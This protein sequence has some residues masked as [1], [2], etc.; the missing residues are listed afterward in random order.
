MK[1][2]STLLH[3][4]FGL[5]LSVEANLV[6]GSE[7]GSMLLKLPTTWYWNQIGSFIANFSINLVPSQ[8]KSE[9][10][11]SSSKETTPRTPKSPP[12]PPIPECSRTPEEGQLFH[13][14]TFPNNIQNQDDYENRKKI[15]CNYTMQAEENS[16]VLLTF[17]HI[18]ISSGYRCSTAWLKVFYPNETV[19]ETFCG[20]SSR[21]FQVLSESNELRLN[22]FADKYAYGN[23]WL[24][25]WQSVPAD[26]EI[27]QDTDDLYFL[28]HPTK[29]RRGVEEEVCVDL[30][31][32]Y[33]D[34]A[35]VSVNF[36][37]HD[38]ES[39][40]IFS[41]EPSLSSV[42][43]QGCSS[44]VL[45][46]TMVESALMRLTIKKSEDDMEPEEVYRF[47]DL[48][49]GEKEETLFQ[50]DKGQYKSGDTVKF[51]LLKLDQ[52][53]KSVDATFS[54]IAV[55][56]PAGRTIQQWR[57]EQAEQGILQKEFELLEES[58][59][60]R[61]TIE[62][63]EGDTEIRTASFKVAEYV[64]PKFEVKVEAPAAIVKGLDSE[65]SVCAEYTHK[66]PVKG[67][68][69]A[70][71]STPNRYSWRRPQENEIKI[72]NRTEDATGED[73]CTKIVLSYEEVEALKNER[74]GEVSSVNLDVVFIEDGTATE[75]KGDR[76]SANTVSQLMKIEFGSSSDQHFLGGLP[77]TGE[78]KSLNHDG[79]PRANE[80]LQVCVRLFKDI[81][82]LKNLFGNSW[83]MNED[84][85][86]RAIPL[87]EELTFRNSCSEVK[88]DAAG[89]LKISVP[90][91][92][93]DTDQDVKKLSIKVTALDPAL[94]PEQGKNLVRPEG[95][96]DVELKGAES[97]LT[98]SMNIKDKSELSCGETRSIPVYVS[99]QK[100][101]EFKVYTTIMAGGVQIRKNTEDWMMKEDPAINEELLA[102]R[103]NVRIEDLPENGE[104]VVNRID[105][106][107]EASPDTFP[108]M[109]VV[110]LLMTGGNDTIADSTEVDVGLCLNNQVTM[111]ISPKK[112]VPDQSTVMKVE[113]G[114]GSVCGLS[115]V[116]K[117][118]NLLGNENKITG[119]S[120][121]D[122]KKRFQNA[123]TNYYNNNYELRSKCP[124][125]QDLL[126]EFTSAGI[127]VMSSLPTFTG[128]QTLTIVGQEEE[129]EENTY[130]VE[131]SMADYD[132]N[133]YSEDHDGPPAPSPIAQSK[134]GG[135][136][137]PPAENQEI[138]PV[139]TEF[140]ETWLFDLQP[141]DDQ[142]QIV[143]KLEAP[144]TLTTWI[145]EAI[146]LSPESG[147]GVATPQNVLVTKDFFGDL[148]LPF[149]VKR[150]E[151]FPLNISV[152]NNLE[153]Q[154]PLTVTI[155]SEEVKPEQVKHELCLGAR[156]SDVVSVPTKADAVGDID[157]LV[158]VEIQNNQDCE[159]VEQGVGFSDRLMKPI[160]V[161]PEGIPVEK[162]NS[163][164][165]C[166]EDDS[167]DTITLP[168][169]EVP[170]DFVV[171]SDRAFVH[172]T[173]DILAPA[174]QNIG[175]L[176]RIPTGC[177][178]QNMVGLAP[179]IYLLQYLDSGSQEA[180]K[181]LTEKAKKYMEIGYNRQQKYRHKAGGYSIWGPSRY[182]SASKKD[183]D[184]KAG[185]TWLTAFV[186]K[187]FAQASNYIKIDDEKLE[188]SVKW[189]LG[190]QQENGCFEKK[191]YVYSSSLQGGNSESSLN[192]FVLLSLIEVADKYKDF[193]GQDRLSEAFNCVQENMNRTDLYSLTLSNYASTLY[194]K[195][196]GEFYLASQQLEENLDKEIADTTEFLMG[197]A[198]SSVPGVLFWDQPTTVDYGYWSY[199]KSMA[200]EMT[201][202]NIMTL[203]LLERLDDAVSSVKWLGRQR[204]SQGGF[205]STQDT[206]VALQALS[207]YGSNVNQY[208]TAVNVKVNSGEEEVVAYDIDDN[209]KQLLNTIKLPAVPSSPSFSLQGS[210]CVLV[211]TVLRY[212]TPELE[213]E[214]AFT[215]KVENSGNELEVCAAYIGTR[216]E[217][218]MVILEV[219]MVSGHVAVNP[220]YLVNEIDS[221]VRR[222][223]VDEKENV[224]E[225]Y[226]D[227]FDRQE[228]CVSLNLRQEFEISELKPARVSI[229]DYQN[230]AERHETTYSLK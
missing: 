183:G 117:S 224:V 133:D 131:Y 166:L 185:S 69:K 123:K 129:Y 90:T 223:D 220:D 203:T 148:R 68:V 209:N 218:D 24:A 8:S 94:L 199:S 71:F 142:G 11:S 216:E 208:T 42:L 122:L 161:K 23:G 120:V 83:S 205:S 195:K 157:I 103:Y 104:A 87:L 96:H 1:I 78:I 72:L 229:Y 228:Q 156:S 180:P 30:H 213:E 38:G 201:A 134:L 136:A 119:K 167:V 113:T 147:I 112:T 44:L 172:V 179:N 70:A 210:G 47:V 124:K 143:K 34:S 127:H 35:I 121:G 177:G 55:K 182:S 51:R 149:S 214:P 9:K 39:K 164:L 29:F 37:N 7:I 222:V 59:L 32:G 163:D 189:L 227:Q 61:W 158:T 116:D 202:Y 98:V 110:V 219:E 85:Y 3:L 74:D 211:Q 86:V 155:R 73:K 36:W 176:V 226:F 15:D 33:P 95:K 45:P 57:D 150:G 108:K 2:F 171:D 184:E 81:Q 159:P 173:G 197:Q 19:Q 190:S 46:D 217:T 18:E 130:G 137:G 12:L 17:H 56:D 187:V 154:L 107:V 145:G 41:E 91:N 28:T 75:E 25:K 6:E 146:C 111:D 128:C 160:R 132:D 138:P 200:V 193:V 26:Y 141:V 5:I 48:I 20:T 174:L 206:V 21:N 58:P 140:P 10:P 66:A 188:E 191:G 181:E 178:E 82:K 151:V 52:D 212:N 67:T 207:L 144:D 50:T 4:H 215:L 169:V 153:R 106:P 139:R 221:G 135:S 43:K 27:Q 63:K 53:M 97:G 77:Y 54:M 76:V 93:L 84:D 175:N 16:K 105:I 168:K 101:K 118:V 194:R 165:K 152:F 192:A 80:L 13:S 31:A 186:V 79:S 109:K 225:L 64:L 22:F 126:E 92:G 65:W 125:L 162:V 88:T 49:S 115:L 114:K 14:D 230:L 60:G 102:D 196:S 40:D 198:N 62:A 89:F 99:G 170:E 100:G 204:N